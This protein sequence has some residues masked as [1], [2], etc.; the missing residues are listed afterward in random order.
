MRNRPRTAPGARFGVRIGGGGGGGVCESTCAAPQATSS[1]CVAG[2]LSYSGAYS[3]S[4]SGSFD[5][6]ASLA[7]HAAEFGGGRVVLRSAG[8]EGSAAA[9]TAEGALR[10]PASAGCLVGGGH[11]TYAGKP[12]PQAHSTAKVPPAWAGSTAAQRVG[13]VVA[14][15]SK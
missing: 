8:W 12:E 13:G 2:H 14:T 9:V 10:R 1:A 11:T 5:S 3:G 7:D 4:Y 15:P 6:S